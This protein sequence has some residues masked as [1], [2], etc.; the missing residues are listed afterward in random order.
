[1]Y[2]ESGVTRGLGM[3]IAARSEPIDAPRQNWILTAGGDWLW[4]IGTPVLALAWALLTLVLLGPVWVISIFV[5]LNASHHL[6]TFLRIYGDKDLFERFRWSLVLGPVLPFCFAMV[7][8]AFLVS[9]GRSLNDFLVLTLITTIWDPWH[10]LMQHYGFMRIY[11]RH[12]H[13]PRRIAAR[14][15]LAL[16][17]SWFVYLMLAALEWLPNLMYELVNQC[18]IWLPG[19]I[20]ISLFGLLHDIFLVV[21]LAVTFGYLYYLAWCRRHGYFISH[22]KL[23][24]M[25]VTFGVMYL[26]YV[27]NGLMEGIINSLR[28]WNPGISEWGFAMGF[29]TVGMVHVTQ[30]LAIVWKYNRSLARRPG[31]ARSGW[32]LRSFTHGGLAVILLYVVFCLFYGFLITWGPGDVL[33]P[34]WLM[35]QDAVAVK[36][37]AG[38]LAAAMF[39]STIMHYYY[40][41]FI[42]KIRHRENRQN[43]EMEDASSATTQSQARS[44]SWWD[45]DKRGSPRHTL[46]RQAVYFLPPILFVVVSYFLA[47]QDEVSR[48]PLT[49][50]RET[51]IAYEED[52]ARFQ[53]RV[54]PALGG[55]DRQMQIELQMVELRKEDA[56]HLVKLAFMNNFYGQL[57]VRK[58]LGNPAAIKACYQHY[59]QAIELLDRAVRSPGNRYHP[60]TEE[61]LDED[62][63]H[64]IQSFWR[65][66]MRGMEGQF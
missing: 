6:P 18:G 14:M 29:A 23:A 54:E 66:Q 8:V 38:T 9:S 57:V 3:T 37:M 2:E 60:E 20:D 13:A 11:D 42:W 55:L 53:D 17:G 56:D 44:G 46:L 48:D 27:P 10:F 47:I 62:Q 43:L 59:Q 49:Y 12:N 45:N 21:A 61:P 51:I 24:L 5:V 41:G 58:D 1:M 40:D 4:I 15:D 34:D 26:T 63:V 32:F 39:T 65:D 22:A 52:P 50:A 25:L 7:V 28:R 64:A 16:C 36:W 19:L 30:Y 33:H 35:N 31:A